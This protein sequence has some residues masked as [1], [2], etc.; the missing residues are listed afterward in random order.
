MTYQYRARTHT[1]TEK[2]AATLTPHDLFERLLAIP[3]AEWEAML[4]K[5][6]SVRLPFGSYRAAKTAHE[7]LVKEQSR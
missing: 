7:G 1:R 5:V 2:G 6:P 3:D 4:A